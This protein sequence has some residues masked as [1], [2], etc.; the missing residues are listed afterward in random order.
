MVFSGHIHDKCNPQKNV[1]YVGSSTQVD[2]TEKPD[3]WACLLSLDEADGFT[4]RFLKLDIRSISLQRL[5]LEE[6]SLPNLSKLSKRHE[7]RLI[8]GASREERSEYQTRKEWKKLKGLGFKITWDID[9]VG[10]VALSK[11][12]KKKDFPSL[13]K[14]LISKSDKN[15]KKA[16]EEIYGEEI[17]EE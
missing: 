4:Y 10:R 8:I 17:A 16:Y 15:I 12:R 5:R 7:V 14:E 2:Y 3:K 9:P 6:I 1:W 11:A 13:L